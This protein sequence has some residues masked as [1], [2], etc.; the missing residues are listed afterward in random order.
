MY[1]AFSSTTLPSPS[2]L[3]LRA[4]L[5]WFWLSLQPEGHSAGGRNTAAPVATL[6]IKTH[7]PYS[8]VTSNGPNRRSYMS[9]AGAEC[10][11]NPCSC[12]F[13]KKRTFPKQCLC[14][15]ARSAILPSSS[16]SLK[17]EVSGSSPETTAPPLAARVY[18]A[19]NYSII[20]SFVAVTSPTVTNLF[21]YISRDH[22]DQWR[23]SPSRV[24]FRWWRVN[25]LKDRLFNF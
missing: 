21:R 13:N 18:C 10:I 17:G 16:T 15:L 20:S 3:T 19:L 14:F 22:T 6:P 9:D 24:I 2:F 4:G 23:G 8:N 5:L 12:T 7:L 11:Y 1:S 25:K